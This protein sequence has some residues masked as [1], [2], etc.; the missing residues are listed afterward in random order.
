VKFSI[1]KVL[2]YYGAAVPYGGGYAKLR[3]PFHDD[4]HPSATVNHVKQTFKCYVCDVSGDAIDVIR[5]REGG[6]YE[7]AKQK[8]AQ[9]TGESGPEVRGQSSFG[10]LGESGNRRGN[11]QNVASWRSRIT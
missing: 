6:G 10:L 2:E 11:S 3:C 7:D 4:R 9:I 8:A 5:W 1:G